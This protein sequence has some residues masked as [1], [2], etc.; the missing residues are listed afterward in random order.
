MVG[1]THRVPVGIACR[2]LNATACVLWGAGES[3]KPV[4]G[5]PRLRVSPWAGES[6][7]RAQ[8]RCGHAEVPFTRFENLRCSL[9]SLSAFS[10][11]IAGIGTEPPN[12]KLTRRFQF[13]RSLDGLT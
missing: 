6:V 4:T 13:P 3:A 9:C 11:L 8:S 1:A 5:N 10:E 12:V 2:I 7:M